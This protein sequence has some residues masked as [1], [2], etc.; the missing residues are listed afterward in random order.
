MSEIKLNTTNFDCVSN[1]YIYDLPESIIASGYSVRTELPTTIA[2]K[3]FLRAQ[4]LSNLAN[5]NPAHGQYLTG[6]RVNFDL[7]FSNKAWIE[8]ER[9]RFFEF[10]SSQSTMHCIVKF[11]IKKQCN[12]YV[13]PEI[14]HILENMV[15]DYHVMQAELK[16][17]TAE[18]NAQLVEKLENEL[19]EQR[20]KILYNVPSGFELTARIT[21][22]YR[23]LKNIYW[24]RYDHGL[25]EWRQFCEW[26][27]QLPYA[28]YLITNSETWQEQ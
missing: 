20:L 23:C 24:Q 10:I 26:I 12:K 2:D 3:D 4:R 22:N 1:A 5:D 8:A 7:R 27:A 21:T 9:Y 15:H 28:E 14:I 16:S 11:D 13:L 25:P 17:A 18:H 6:I 19:K